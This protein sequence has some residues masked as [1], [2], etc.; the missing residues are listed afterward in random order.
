MGCSDPAGR[1]SHSCSD[2]RPAARVTGLG[3]RFPG[4]RPAAMTMAYRHRRRFRIVVVPLRRH[5]TRIAPVFRPPTRYQPVTVA[6]PWIAWN[7]AVRPAHLPAMHRCCRSLSHWTV[8]AGSAATTVATLA[9][10]AG[11]AGVIAAMPSTV[12][13]SGFVAVTAGWSGA[14]AVAGRK[15]SAVVSYSPAPTAAARTSRA[16]RN[17]HSIHANWQP[18]THSSNI[19]RNW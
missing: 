12:A 10:P 1:R 6:N 4:R 9:R 7:P 14:A 19:T 18:G 8:P 16:S 11:S 3:P 2:R 13:G 15:V 5:P 17:A